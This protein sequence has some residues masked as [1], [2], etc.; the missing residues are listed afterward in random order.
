MAARLL[1][2]L[3]IVLGSASFA[4]ALTTLALVKS[5]SA[6]SD[7][8][9]ISEPVDTSGQSDMQ[10]AGDPAPAAT[11]DEDYAPN[12]SKQRS[13][14]PGHGC[15]NRVATASFS[16]SDSLGSSLFDF[17]DHIRGLQQQSRVSEE[18]SRFLGNFHQRL[19]TLLSGFFGM[20]P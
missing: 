12:V 3:R 2:A 4:G 10:T 19:C 15:D 16:H 1:L 11:P 17:R 6:Q 8:Q 7:S 20:G 5:S 14:Q 13:R 18:S 9:V